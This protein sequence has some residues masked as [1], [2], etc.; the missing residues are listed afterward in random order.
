LPGVTSGFPL[1]RELLSHLAT[2]QTSSNAKTTGM[3]FGKYFTVDIL[4][5]N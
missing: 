4:S 5:V 3:P 2:E 1:S